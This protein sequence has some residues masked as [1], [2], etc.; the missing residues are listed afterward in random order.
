VT[1]NYKYNFDMKVVQK[2]NSYLV[3]NRLC[4]NHENKAAPDVVYE[5]NL[6]FFLKITRDHPTIVGLKSVQKGSRL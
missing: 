2:F 6:I 5:R 3:Q 1:K 4:L